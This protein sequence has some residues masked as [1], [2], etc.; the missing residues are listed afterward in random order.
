V[1]DLPT[2]TRTDLDAGVGMSSENIFSRLEGQLEQEQGEQAPL[3]MSDILDLPA[4]QGDLMR[5]VLR[6]QKPLTPPEI[7]QALG[8]EQ[9]ATD[10]VIGDLSLAG[11]IELTRWLHQGLPHATKYS[12]HPR[13]HVEHPERPLGP[14]RMEASSDKPAIR[15]GH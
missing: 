4:E 11:M 7:S 10:R 13:W 14:R 9:N 1:P 8:W 12:H 2:T 3:T 15:H 6:A 5:Q